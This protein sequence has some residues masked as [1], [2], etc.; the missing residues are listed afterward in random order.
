MVEVLE[1]SLVFLVSSMFVGF[2][3]AAFSSYSS[4]AVSLENRAAFSSVTA[5]AWDA[6]EHGS[7]NVSVVFAGST[8]SCSGGRLSLVSTSYSG[9]TV[10]PVGC[11]FS[12]SA[13]NGTHNLQFVSTSSWLDLEVT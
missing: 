2:S 10:L 1:Y 12:D 5:A 7:A 9:S 3:F 4:S 13:L 6:I 11:E 8:V